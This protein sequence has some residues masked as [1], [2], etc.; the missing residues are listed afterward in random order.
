MI[1]ASIK[2]KMIFMRVLGAFL[3]KLVEYHK[4]YKSTV[5]LRGFSLTLQNLQ[6]L[7]DAKLEN[8]RDVCPEEE[9]FRN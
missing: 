7:H 3:V 8:F 2:S 5:D 9:V 4:F 6:F 1:S